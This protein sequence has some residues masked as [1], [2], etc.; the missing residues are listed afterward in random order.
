MDRFECLACGQLDTRD[1]YSPLCPACGEPLFVVPAPRPGGRRIREE[2]ALALE[3]FADFLPLERLDPALS[4]GEGSTPL[5]RLGRLGRRLGLDGLFAKNEAQNPTASFKD[6]GTA[7][8]VQKAAAFGAGRIGT[9]STGNMAASTAAYG[10]RAGLQT[11]VL[12]KEGTSPA[13]LLGAGVYKPHLVAVRGDYGAVFE[14]SLAIG[15]RL[16]IP[17]M[18][19]IDPY[20]LEGYKLT[21]FE[22]FLQLGRR[23]PDAVVV[24]L[25]SGGHLLGLMR[26]FADLE[27]EG[28]IATFP[29]IVGVQAEPCSPLVRA[30]ERGLPRWERID[31]GPTRAHAIANPAPPGGNAVLRLIRERD[32]LLAAVSDEDMF[33]AQAELAAGEGLFCQPESATTLAAV[34]KLAAAGRLRLGG[35]GTVLVLTGQGLK[36]MHL[37][38]PARVAIQRLDLGGLEEGLARLCRPRAS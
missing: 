20:R 8:A 32:G 7:V 9:V 36:T 10:A 16:G 5:V 31:A 26:G 18:N 17:F 4:L 33:E 6:R 38:D 24:P 23:A 27:R 14:A 13:G 30:F 22:I 25:S 21:A 29:Q 2:R 3:R 12:L 11:F 35:G 19:S 28:L 1:F 37:L 15:R 34:K